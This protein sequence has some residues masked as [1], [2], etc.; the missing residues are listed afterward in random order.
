V[1][2]LI[3]TID[4]SSPEIMI[5]VWL[6]KAKNLQGLV[7]QQEDNLEGHKQNR[8]VPRG[9]RKD[10]AQKRADRLVVRGAG[11]TPPNSFIIVTKDQFLMSE[12]QMARKLSR[13]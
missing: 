10:Q 2:L 11:F 13:N 12:V 6:L 5:S 7:C 4:Y 3:P 1:P 9:G 8:F